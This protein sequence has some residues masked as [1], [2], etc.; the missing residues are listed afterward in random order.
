MAWLVLAALLLAL[1]LA[2][3][4]KRPSPSASSEDVDP[5][6]AMKAAVEL[7][8]IRRRFD[9]SWTRSQQ[10]REAARVRRE[11]AEAFEGGDE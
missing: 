2:V 9:V 8:R 3:N 11:I 10:R 1:V 7:H 6:Q 5:E 4:L